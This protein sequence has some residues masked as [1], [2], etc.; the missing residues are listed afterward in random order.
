M[1]SISHCNID[2]IR[3]NSIL[4]SIMNERCISSLVYL[5]ASFTYVVSLKKFGNWFHGEERKEE[6]EWDRSFAYA[7]GWM[8]VRCKRIA[9]ERGA[10]NRTNFSRENKCMLPIISEGANRY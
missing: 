9:R 1:Y 4:I 6:E 3:M 8:R 5:Y 7:I 10:D 2:C